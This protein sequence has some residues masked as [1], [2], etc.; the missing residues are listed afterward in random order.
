MILDAEEVAYTSHVGLKTFPSTD[1]GPS[2]RLR[3]LELLSHQLVARAQITKSLGLLRQ[4]AIL[5]LDGA[6]LIREIF[7]GLT[8]PGLRALEVVL[9]RRQ[10]AVAVPQSPLDLGIPLGRLCNKGT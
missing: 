10:V 4:R 9:H 6:L 8:K 1:C 7:L 3:L 2:G 5:L